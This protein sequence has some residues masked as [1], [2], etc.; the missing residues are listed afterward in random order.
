MDAEDPVEVSYD[1][2]LTDSQISRYVFHTQTVISRS[3]AHMTKAEGKRIFFLSPVSAVVQLRPQLNHIDATEETSKAR[4]MRGRKDFDE[5]AAREPDARPVDVK[6]MQDERWD[7]YGWVDA[8][9]E[10][11]W[12]TYENYMIHNEPDDLPQ[13]ESA[14]DGEIAPPVD[15]AHPAMTGWA[16]KQNRQKQREVAEAEHQ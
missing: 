9:T 13:L 10:E 16:M 5:D 12:Y 14:V 15:P 11:A 8:E 6:K 3:E 2:F 4:I 7:P 1:V